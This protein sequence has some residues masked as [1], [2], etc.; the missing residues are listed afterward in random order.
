MRV[1]VAGSF[2]M[3]VFSSNVYMCLIAMILG[4][5]IVSLLISTVRIALQ[6]LRRLSRR[7][8][9]SSAR[10]TDLAVLGSVPIIMSG[11][12][13]SIAYWVVYEMCT[14]TRLIPSGDLT[15]AVLGVG[16]AAV[17]VLTKTV[18]R[19]RAPLGSWRFLD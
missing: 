16:A 14:G 10:H 9:S 5:S 7:S 11:V 4:D 1:H 6:P 15:F 8:V 2:S 3:N 18:S 17:L 12:V 19:G 13:G